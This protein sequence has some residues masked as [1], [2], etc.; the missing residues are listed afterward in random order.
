MSK[1]TKKILAVILAVIV[2]GVAAWAFWPTK[3]E[4]GVADFT[5]FL[6]S[7][8]TRNVQNVP[9]I[10]SEESPY[11]ALIATPVAVYYDGAVQKVSPLLAFC[12]K[13]PSR[14]VIQF[15]DMYGNPPVATMGDVP[16]TLS[17]NEREWESPTEVTID[18]TGR[19]FTGSLKDIS[20]NVA[21]HF[22]SHSDGVIIIG[23]NQESYN[24]AVVVL[25]LASYLN[26]PVIVI[27]R[28]EKDVA[29]VL[30][31]LGVRYSIVCNGGTT[32]GTWN[33]EGYEKTKRFASPE[34]AQNWMIK[35]VK[36]RLG[37]EVNYITMANPLDIYEQEVLA[38]TIPDWSPASG[39]IDHEAATSYPGRPEM[40]VGPCFKFNIP[41]KYAN[42]KIDV[43]LDIS[44]ETWGD[45]SGARI[46]AF[47]GVDTDG[48]GK[49]DETIDKI[50]FFS[51]SPAYENEGYTGDPTGEVD[52]ANQNLIPV[53]DGEPKT[54]TARLK[55]EIPIFNDIGEH[56]I[57][58]IA[59][60]PTDDERSPFS[61]T[62]SAPYTL[63]LE[64]EELDS[65][66]YPRIHSASSFAGY[67]TAYHKG[68]VL[69]KSSYMIYSDTYGMIDDPNDP[70][71]GKIKDS[72]NPAANLNL[73]EPTN[74][75]VGEVKRD[76]NA[77]LA[78]L[79]NPANPM[80]TNTSADIIALA[81]YYDAENANG[82]YTYLA[83]I[84]DPSMVPHY[85]YP[86]LGL[87]Q[88]SLEGYRVPSDV[89]Y[90]DIDADLSLP[91]YGLDG[92]YPR[93]ELAEGRVTGFCVQD[94]SALLSRTF[95]YT[96]IIQNLIGPWNGNIDPLS[97][98]PENRVDDLWKNSGTTALGTEPP[99]GS[100]VTALD[101]VSAMWEQVGFSSHKARPDQ[102]TGSQ[103]AR[104]REAPYY[105]SANFIYICAHGFY[106]WY[107]PSS[108]RSYMPYFEVGAGGAF[109]VAHVKL[110]NF[111]PSVIWTDSCVTGR[112][113]GLDP[114]NCV[115]HA[116]LHS[117]LACYFG[118]TRSMWGS[119]VPIPDAYSGE[120]LGSLL[121]LYM[122]GHLTGKLYNKTLE[123][124]EMVFQDVTPQDVST[125]VA[126]MLARNEFIVSEGTDGSDVNDDTYEEVLLH[127]D[128]AFNPYEPNHEGTA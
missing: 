110:M 98:N 10:V 120:M 9:V 54:T 62:W 66:I 21:K 13:N 111:G 40:G 128:P 6:N 28:M 44:H 77:L 100:A 23:A 50:Q 35:I 3:Y 58:V 72:S 25:P 29:D 69:A 119:F 112:I 2:I 102:I 20:L 97:L 82:N 70:D 115:S 61:S 73:I 48:D 127:G 53:S 52:A 43:T 17:S 51:G 125:G 15:L 113:D 8:S 36:Q 7:Q 45:D 101:K 41:Y 59:K 85:Y 107:V 56:A 123:S 16:T 91:P 5:D 49:L 60:I 71:Y 64:V 18:N 103:G 79:P 37:S 87:G 27:D 76:L 81:D 42:I 116:F 86:S 67:L 117:G 74:M 93:L 4:K 46:Y 121:G 109:D 78:R 96:D 30:K 75:R 89:A 33:V 63:T 118:G 80:P 124:G 22:W 88:D 1:G 99:V 90:S 105:E 108:V 95:F 11:L 83:T 104:Q 106:Y 126:F 12:E 38:T 26:I 55:T 34:E 94:I 47:L 65:Y 68:V 122:Y 14:A 24:T 31:G 57:Q 39:E 32:G 19:A 92:R 114:R 84:A